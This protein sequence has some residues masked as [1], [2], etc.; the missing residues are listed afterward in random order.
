MPPS[1]ADVPAVERGGANGRDPDFAAL[2]NEPAS[3]LQE[4]PRVDQGVGHVRIDPERSHEVGNDQV[5][6]FR[7]AHAPRVALDEPHAVAEAV[8]GRQ[9][10]RQPDDRMALDR[11]HPAGARL[12][13]Q[14]SENAGA[15]AQ[16]DHDRARPDGLAQRAADGPEAGRVGEEQMMKIEGAHELFGFEMQTALM[17]LDFPHARLLRS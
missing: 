10:P 8:L 7:E 13:R 12:Q 6:A 1:R 14:E 5:G 11:V 16:V 4:A 2:G 9:S 15:G 3:L 17:G